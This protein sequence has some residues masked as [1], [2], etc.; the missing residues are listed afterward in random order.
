MKYLQVVAHD[1]DSGVGTRKFIVDIIVDDPG[2][3]NV[4]L[5][6]NHPIVNYLE[7]SR[8]G[9]CSNYS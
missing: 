9:K 5:P 4:C 8:M 2:Y 1:F 6:R 3:H 7:Q